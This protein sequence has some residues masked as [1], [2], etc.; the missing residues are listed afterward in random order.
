MDFR[1]SSA[2][3]SSSAAICGFRGGAAVLHFV[4]HLLVLEFMVKPIGEQA[5]GA[6]NGKVK[7]CFLGR[8]ALGR[9]RRSVAKRKMSS[10][11][12]LERCHTFCIFHRFIFVGEWLCRVC[13]A[14]ALGFKR[15][16]TGDWTHEYFVAHAE[17]LNYS[18]V[19]EPEKL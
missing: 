16:G 2:C 11:I 15:F 1:S 6:L 7:V 19:V 13:L 8:L 5:R 3:V 17:V 18:A 14:G 4:I 12:H 9:C 10:M